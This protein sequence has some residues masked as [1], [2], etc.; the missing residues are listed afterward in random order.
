LNPYPVEIL[1]GQL[2]MGDY[3]QATN[4]KILKD[5]KLNALVNVSDECSLM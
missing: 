2:Y 5:L 1:P 4:P 3:R